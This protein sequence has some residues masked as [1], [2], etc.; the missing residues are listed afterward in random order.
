MQTDGPRGSAQERREAKR[1]R[2]QKGYALTPLSSAL[3]SLLLYMLSHFRHV[4]LFVTLWTVQPVRLLCPWD[5]PGEDTEVGCHALLQG[6]FLTQ[7]SNL[8]LLNL[9]HRRQILYCWATAR[10]SFL[11]PFLMSVYLPLPRHP[12]HSSVASSFKKVLRWAEQVNQKIETKL[13]FT[14]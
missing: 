4:W 14:F 12:V 2:E 7:G 1:R 9:L 8:R 5:S 10:I 13:A 11:Q 6:V 3:E